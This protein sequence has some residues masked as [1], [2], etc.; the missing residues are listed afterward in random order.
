MIK[1]FRRIRQRLLAENKI[2]KYLLYA[3]GEIVLV[4]IGILIALQINNWNDEQKREL[5]TIGLMTQVRKELLQN[6]K[7]TDI[8][9]D[10]YFERDSLIYKVIKKKVTSEDYENNQLYKG[11]PWDYTFADIVDDD[12]LN[13][14]ENGKIISSDQDSLLIRL[15]ELYSIDKLSIDKFE[16][17]TADIANAFK[18][19]IKEEQSWFSDYRAELITEE[20][21]EFFLNEP[22][23]LNAVYDVSKISYELHLYRI[24]SFR[25][26]A[27]EIYQAI[28]DFLGLEENPIVKR[29]LN[30]FNHYLGHYQYQHSELGNITMDIVRGSENNLIQ[31]VYQ[32]D[33]LIRT[34]T[35]YPYSK[36]HFI[37]SGYVPPWQLVIGKTNEIEGVIMVGIYGNGAQER[38]YFNKID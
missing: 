31:H 5:V 36:T 1:F 34:S 30:D 28:S 18:D 4:V 37:R 9:L 7:R 15:K 25:Y 20:M 16:S 12:F 10:Y 33:S 8:V 21:I 29:D 19:K 13:L 32:N 11:L 23:Y 2:S 14:L 3:I 35:I 22:Y 6:I 27:G 26:K 38:P 24:S 17:Y